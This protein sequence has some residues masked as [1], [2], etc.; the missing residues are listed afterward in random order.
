VINARFK[1]SRVPYVKYAKIWP[2]YQDGH[3]RREHS[4][5]CEQ[6]R[7]ASDDH[8]KRALFEQ[9]DSI[10]T[11]QLSETW[12][13]III[14]TAV[15]HLWSPK[16]RQVEFYE[17]KKCVEWD[18]KLYTLTRSHIVISGRWTNCKAKRCWS[19]KQWDTT[20]FERNY[21]QRHNFGL[22]SGGTN[23]EGRRTR[24]PLVS[25]REGRKMGRRLPPPHPILGSGK[26]HEFSSGSGTVFIVI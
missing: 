19:C 11:L 25:R 26:A 5:A 17:F 1:H 23:L 9:R 13:A 3:V 21:E 2:W 4:F 18:V 22:K 12:N 15:I 10:L 20:K 8:L 16:V 6:S 24:R 14:H 7:I